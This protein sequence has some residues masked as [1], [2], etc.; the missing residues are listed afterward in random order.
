MFKTAREIAVVGV[1]TALLIGGQLALAGIGGGEI[2]TV[3]LLSF[4]VVFGPLRGMAVATAFSLLRCFIW[5]FFPTVIVL[6]LVYYN[7]FALVIGV[8]G[9]RAESIN[10]ALFIVLLTVTA[11]VLTASFSMMDN[12]ITPLMFGMSARATKMYFM[13][14][15]PFMTRQVICSAITVPLLYYPLYRAFK[16]AD[17]I[18]EK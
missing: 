9:K 3:L 2:V 8:M 4:C 5:G 17:R 10:K 1:M 11:C 6:Y 14:S 16:A 12:L 18:S 7:L 15:L 13:S